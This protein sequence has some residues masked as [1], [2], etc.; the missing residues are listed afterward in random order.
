VQNLPWSGFP[1]DAYCFFCVVVSVELPALELGAALLSLDE[2][3]ALGVLGVL[4]DEL[5]ELGLADEPAL[6]VEEDE[7]ELLGVLGVVTEP[8]MDDEDDGGVLE[9][10]DE[11]DDGLDGVVVL[12]ED[13]PAEDLSVERDA[14]GPPG[15][16]SQP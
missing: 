1:R 8:D 4:L 14:P 5:E 10:D 11:D 16:L 12:E 15:P 9:P 3:E 13:E 7:L 2:L 6:G